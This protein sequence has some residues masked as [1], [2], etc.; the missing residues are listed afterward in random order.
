MKEY[1]FYILFFIFSISAFTQERQITA[2]RTNEEI[3]IDGLINEEAW[4][5]AE[6]T[7]RFCYL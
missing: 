6:C 7:G 2:Y 4:S 3:K 1:I 5:K